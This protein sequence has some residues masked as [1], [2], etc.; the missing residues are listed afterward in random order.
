MNTNNEKNRPNRAATQY[1]GRRGGRSGHYTAI[2]SGNIGP[3]TKMFS[4]HMLNKVQFS[5]DDCFTK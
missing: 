1:L 2:I 4:A 3:A 5:S